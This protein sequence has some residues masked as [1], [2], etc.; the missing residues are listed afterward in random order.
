MIHPAVLGGPHAYRHPDRPRH[1]EPIVASGRAIA[2]A[3]NLRGG[4]GRP[5]SDQGI[6][7][8]QPFLAFFRIVRALVVVDQRDNAG[9]IAGLDLLRALP[10]GTRSG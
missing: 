7:A 2:D 6:Q 9:R 4:T 10:Q 5:R 1:Q 3:H 8:G